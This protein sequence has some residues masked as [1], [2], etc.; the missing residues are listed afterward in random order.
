MSLIE[1]TSNRLHDDSG[2]DIALVGV[3]PGKSTIISIIIECL[4]PK[5]GSVTLQTKGIDGNDDRRIAYIDYING[6]GRYAVTSAK[7]YFESTQN[8]NVKIIGSLEVRVNILFW[9]ID[10]W[11]K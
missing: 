6:K 9:R 10:T 8:L 3:I 7:D 2:A 1:Y 5:S 11:K 4:S